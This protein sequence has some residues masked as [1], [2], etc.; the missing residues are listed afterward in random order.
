[1]YQYPSIDGPNKAPHEPCV[2][3]EK[4]DGSNLR[5]EWH[6][7]RGWCKQGSRHRLFDSTDEHLGPAIPIFMS[8]Y[9]EAVEKAVRDSKAYRNAELVT[10]FAE[11][12]GQ[13]SFAGQHKPDDPKDLVL[14]DLHV[15]KKGILGPSEFLSLLGHIDVARVVYQGPLNATLVQDVRDGKFP[16][17]HRS[18]EGVVCKGGSGHGLWMRKI[19]TTAYMDR[20]KNSFGGEWEKFGE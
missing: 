18:N 14:F 3:F 9:A 7:K 10:A 8:K 11:F 5:W 19:K 17:R 4:I 13:D 20:L 2:A 1:M 15:L 12:F 16:N 6:R